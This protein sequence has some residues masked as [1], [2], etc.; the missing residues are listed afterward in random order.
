MILVYVAGPYRAP[1]VWQVEQNIRRA[2]EMAFLVWRLGAVPVTPHLLGRHLDKVLP[3]PHVLQAMLAVLKMCHVLVT[4]P[5]WQ[6]SKG[7]VDEIA[8]ATRLGIPTFD[9]ENLKIYLKG[10]G[11]VPPPINMGIM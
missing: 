9:L 8:E 3:D 11:V 7:T 10:R 1:N 5:N 2:E 4:V 6:N